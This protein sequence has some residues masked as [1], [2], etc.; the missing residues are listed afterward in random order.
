[1][2]LNFKILIYL[3]IA[4]V[5]TSNSYAVKI[6]KKGKG[7]L[8]LSE[9]TAHV[10]EYYFSGGT[11]GKW[12][13]PEKADWNPYVIAIS[14][15]G[16]YF[17][18]IRQPKKFASQNVDAKN[19]SALAVGDCKKMAQ[20][21]GYPQEC[22]LFAVK[23]KIVWDNGSDKKR[24]RLKKSEIKAGKTFSILKE[25]DFYKG[26]SQIQNSNKNTS[27][28]NNSN[29]SNSELVEQLKSLKKLYDDGVLSKKE[30]EK[31]KKKILN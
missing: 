1:M 7:P 28:N 10:L 3:L 15:D 27:S 14:E 5:F 29:T 13:E 30:F 25:L 24:R 31:A 26:E 19:Y 22:F 20:K 2:L 17:G 16:H 6:Y 8:N 11:K 21:D 12:A 9:N 4:L 18:I 23:K